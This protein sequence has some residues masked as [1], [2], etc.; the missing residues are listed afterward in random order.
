MVFLS[1]VFPTASHPGAPALGI[2]RWAGLAHQ[3]GLPVLA[4]GGVSG[5]SVGRLPRICAGIGMIG[6][7]V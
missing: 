1:P 5:V 7:A 6:A 3:A 4:L 2:V